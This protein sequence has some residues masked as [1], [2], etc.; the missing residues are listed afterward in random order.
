MA[1]TLKGRHAITRGTIEQF[2]ERGK[3]IVRWKE[4]DGT[5]HERQF[6]TVDESHPFFLEVLE[7]ARADANPKLDVREHL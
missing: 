2:E 3:W 7:A 5:P 6:A 1:E 4:A